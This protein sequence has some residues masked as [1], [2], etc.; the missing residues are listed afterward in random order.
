MANETRNIKYWA[1][2]NSDDGVVDS[3]GQQAAITADFP[4]SP[5]DS[6]Q[7]YSTDVVY[8]GSDGAD[9]A[10]F[11]DPDNGD[12]YF[13]SEST[14]LSVGDSI[15]QPQDGDYPNDEVPETFIGISSTIPNQD[16]GDS[17][18][19]VFTFNVD[20]SGDVSEASS[21]E[22]LFDPGD[23]NS[24]DFLDPPPATQ[25]IDFA[26][27]E[28]QKYIEIKVTGDTL[29]ESDESFTLSLSDPTNAAIQEDAGSASSTI[30]NDD[31]G[32]PDPYVEPVI[33]LATTDFRQEEGDQG[34][35]DHIFFVT[36]AGDLS[37]ASA[38][39]VVF[40]AGDTDAADFAGA[41][42]ETQTVF[43]APDEAVQ[44][45]SVAVSG[46]TDI[47][48][49]EAFSLTLGEVAGA[50]ISDTDN[51]ANAMI[52]NDDGGD[53]DPPDPEPEDPELTVGTDGPDSE[54]GTFGD[55]L[56]LTLGGDDQ[57]LGLGGNDTIDGGGDNDLIDAGSGDDHI[58]GSDGNDLIYGGAGNDH[59]DGGSGDDL[60][61]DAEGNDV[62]RGGSG[63]DMLAGGAGDDTLSG[64]SDDDQLNGGSGNDDLVGGSGND[65]FVSDT[66][67]GTLSDDGFVNRSLGNDSVFDF[68][69]GEDTLVF[70]G[71]DEALN[72]FSDLDTNG[73]GVLDEAD[74][75]V[76]VDEGDTVIDLGGQTDGASEGTLTLVGVTGLEADDMAFS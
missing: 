58:D 68:A 57:I 1:W 15:P 26:A 14:Q 53:P 22:V 36:R 48:N 71:F 50:T 30:L 65:R 12:I 35:T 41:L 18:N 52:V 75:H 73:N 25:T 29:V 43:F 24:K 7:F 74:A 21:V 34:T 49:D 11:E 47:E 60:L 5:G 66:A 67:I 4:L 3:N 44:K 23:T 64:G 62:L 72:A 40:N 20:R 63:N 59:L 2:D 32:D 37:K 46:D 19:T 8:L 28:N 13:V 51:T 31:G 42:P 55:D 61:S 10:I 45:V 16:E 56:I 27:N 70:R 6:A 17:G 54:I 39:Q 76:T 69:Q 33:S 9:G 38:V